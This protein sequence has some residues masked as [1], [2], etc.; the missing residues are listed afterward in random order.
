MAK[1]ENALGILDVRWRE[2][3]ASLLTS[4]DGEFLIMLWG[5]GS[6][7][8]GWL[9][10]RDREQSRAGLPS[11]VCAAIGRPEFC[12]L[13]VDGKVL[14]AATVEQGEYWIVVHEF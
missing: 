6:I 7:R 14:C 4:H 9:R 1:Q 5:P 11:R 3:A 8:K 10:V 12:C 13:S 2:A